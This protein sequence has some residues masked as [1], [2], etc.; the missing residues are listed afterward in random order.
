MTVKY[1]QDVAM[2]VYN[3]RLTAQHARHARILGGRNLSEGIRRAIAAAYKLHTEKTEKTPVS[4][5]PS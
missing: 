2:D 1:E 5:P 3:V 4:T